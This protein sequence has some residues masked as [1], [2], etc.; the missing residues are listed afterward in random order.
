[1]LPIASCYRK[2]TPVR[3]PLSRN[4]P[5]ELLL[6]SLNGA[7]QLEARPGKVK[8]LVEKSFPDRAA[9]DACQATRCQRGGSPAKPAPPRCRCRQA[10]KLWRVA[11]GF[12]QGSGAERN[13]DKTALRLRDAPKRT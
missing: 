9:A 10:W 11:G 7:T 4:P 12:R 1:M 3:R 2:L 5:N 6:K 8:G 13:T